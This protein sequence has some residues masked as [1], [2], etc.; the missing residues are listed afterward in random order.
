[1]NRMIAELLDDPM[2]QLLMLADRV[3]QRALAADLCRLAWRRASVKTRAAAAS[4]PRAGDDPA[5]P[6]SAAD[7]AATTKAVPAVCGATCS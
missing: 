2:T 1:M 3:D 5:F 7:V 6:P 4:Q